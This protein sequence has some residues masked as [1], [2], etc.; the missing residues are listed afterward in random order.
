MSSLV[1]R[2]HIKGADVGFSKQSA[3]EPMGF[4]VVDVETTGLSPS[5]DRVIEVAVVHLD[6]D[7]RIVGEFCTLIDPHRNVGPTHIHGITAADVTGAPTFATAAAV[8]WQQL[9]GRVLVAHN[10]S[11]DVRFLNAEFGRCGVQLPPPPVMCTMQLSSHYLHDLPARTLTACCASAN[12]ELSHHHSALDDARA[13]AQLFGQFR[14]AQPHLP[15]SWREALTKA[16][17]TAWMP[18]PPEYEF[19]PV[20]RAQQTERHTN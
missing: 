14:A 11:F 17:A 2:V 19:Q 13:A 7:G 9:S 18:A 6:I 3:V 20:T 5:K 4:A 16:S 15:N 8:L 10:A 12:V 1:S